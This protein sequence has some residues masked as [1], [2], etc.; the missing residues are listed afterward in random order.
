MFG[1]QLS[2][3]LRVEASP[4][5]QL[6]TLNPQLHSPVRS[7]I[8]IFYYGGPSHLETWDPKPDAPAEIRGEF[9]AVSTSAPG[10]RIGEHLPHCAK[11]MH[12]MALIRSMHH[13]MTNHNAAAAET[14]SGRTP[15]GGDLE[16]LQ[17]DTHS[18][19]HMGSALAY[20]LRDNSSRLPFVA[21]PHVMH[22]VV[23]LPGQRAGFLG[24]AHDPMQIEADPS[25]S[26]F[27]V[28][29]LDL[30][31]NLSLSRL[32]NRRGMLRRIDG[33]ARQAEALSSV[34]APDTFRDRAFRVLTSSEVRRAFA[35]DEEP[36]PIR[37]RYGRNKHGQSV[38]LARRLVE[39]GARFVTVYDGVHNGQ[40]ANWDSHEK[41]FARHRD[42]LLP[43][44]DRALA[45]LV[46]DLH[47][48]GLLDSTLVLA[49]GEFGRTP[50]INGGGGRDHWPHCYSVALA[51]GGVR[52]GMVYGESDA[53]GAYPAVDAATPADLAATLFWRFGV[54][55]TGEIRDLT[56]R[57]Y[58]LASG[59]PIRKL[60]GA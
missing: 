4:I 53:T 33:Y 23:V 49:F 10:I 22:N 35:I 19:P 1:L 26:P 44:A 48:R 14:L 31:A 5:P 29:D 36:A 3:L 2:S 60:V 57:P 12:R 32:E 38:L 11:V 59:E 34:K 6:S 50:K 30:S 45:A 8:L 21:I 7:C 43:P 18:H 24:S 28:P 9:R 46:E 58:P 55:H 47:D 25:V 40:D 16:L 27:K 54:D 17:D 52:G 51:G 56:N 41:L 42:H 37:D 13:P 15:L 20:A 39:A